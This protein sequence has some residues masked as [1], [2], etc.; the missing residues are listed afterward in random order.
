MAADQLNLRLDPA[1]IKK[2]EDDARRFGLNGK[3]RAA[4]DIIE[5]Y[6]EHWHT[7]QEEMHAL[8]RSHLETLNLKPEP[9]RRTGTK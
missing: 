4:A 3:N 6:Y 1:F 8:K 7:M 5:T 2:L 9:K